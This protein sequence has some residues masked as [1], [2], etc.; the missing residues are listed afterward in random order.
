MKN[1]NGTFAVARQPTTEQLSMAV[2][3]MQIASA[4]NFVL[5]NIDMFSDNASDDEFDKW[6]KKAW[7]KGAKNRC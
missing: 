2:L 7:A 4:S 5:S 3:G 6:L 1:E